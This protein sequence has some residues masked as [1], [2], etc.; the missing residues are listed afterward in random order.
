[1]KR[2]QALEDQVSAEVNLSPLIDVVF[3]LLIFFM[4]TTVFVDD[5]GVEVEKPTAATASALDSRSIRVA[6]RAD[7]QIFTGGRS[8]AR[9]DLRAALSRQAAGEERMVLILADRDTRTGALLEVI[10]ECRGLKLPYV[11]AAEEP[12]V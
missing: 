5:V 2:L 3:L 1:M 11:V 10:D 7:G 12:G 6:I 8:I 4:V 9:N